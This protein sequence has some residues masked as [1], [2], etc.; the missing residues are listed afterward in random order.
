MQATP[1]HQRDNRRECQS[2]PAGHY[3]PL[4]IRIASGAS[5]VFACCSGHQSTVGIRP[6]K[7]TQGVKSL[8]NSMMQQGSRLGATPSQQAGC[9]ARGI[10]W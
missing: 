7:W 3:A 10:F 1:P 9:A 8:V 5:A 2:T 6:A 4:W